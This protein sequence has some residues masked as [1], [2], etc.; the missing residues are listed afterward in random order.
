MRDWL[1]NVFSRQI[2]DPAR[3]VPGNPRRPA[4]WPGP[5]RSCAIRSSETSS[6]AAGRCA[7]RSPGPMP[8]SQ[9]SGDRG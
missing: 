6:A 5:T 1:R 7:N 9:R 8:A 3:I 4:P 2:L